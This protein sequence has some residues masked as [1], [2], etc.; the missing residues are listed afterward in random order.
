MCGIAAFFAYG[1][2][3]CG[4]QNFD[5]DEHGRLYLPGKDGITVIDNAGN[6]ILRLDETVSA[7][8]A[9]QGP[10]LHLGRPKYLACTRK[11]LYVSDAFNLRVLRIALGHAAEE[12]CEGQVGRLL[13]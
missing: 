2:C 6:K 12:T 1:G 10:A 7:G 8:A 4:S 5:L 13:E 3:T 11:A 9:G